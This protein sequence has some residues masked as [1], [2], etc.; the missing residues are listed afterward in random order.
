[1][2]L[3]WVPTLLGFFF[4]KSEYMF[5]GGGIGYTINAHLSSW[6]GGFGAGA[7]IIFS[8]T[9]FAVYTFNP[10]FNWLGELFARK[11][12]AEEVVPEEETADPDGWVTPNKLKEKM[13]AAA[14]TISSI[15]TPSAVEAQPK[16]AGPAFEVEAP[17]VEEPME[18]T[19]A[20]KL[21]LDALE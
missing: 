10:S 4:A 19:N 3:F 12:S 5:L 15:V 11:A 16:P 7:L 2:S 20:V 13:A 9:A 8:A 17:I 1:M 6:L 14:S 21:H 18:V